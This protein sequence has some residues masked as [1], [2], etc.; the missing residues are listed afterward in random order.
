LQET[1]IATLAKRIVE[2]ITPA[3]NAAVPTLRI[4]R[5]TE[6]PNGIAEI[7][8]YHRAGVA[9]PFVGPS[10]GGKVPPIDETK[11]RELVAAKELK[12][13]KIY[14]HRCSEVWLVVLVDS[15]L[16]ASMA[17]VPTEFRLSTSRFGRVVALQNWSY[18]INL[19]GIS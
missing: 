8:A 13:T 17:Y 4:Q 1:H 7:W 2:L 19:W 18:T 5:R 3:G 6:L 15:H 16:V 11:L 14:Q 10:W 12:L 9:E